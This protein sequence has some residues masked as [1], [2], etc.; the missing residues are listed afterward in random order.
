MAYKLF[1][2][3]DRAHINENCMTHLLIPKLL[4]EL[5]LSQQNG[6]KN[7]FHTTEKCQNDRFNDSVLFVTF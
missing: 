3:S 5:M 2:L 4:T 6:K 1:H 7:S